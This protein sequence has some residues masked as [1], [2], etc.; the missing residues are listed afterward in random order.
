MSDLRQFFIIFS[1]H[2]LLFVGLTLILKPFQLLGTD[3]SGLYLSLI[4][5]FYRE[6]NF[7]SSYYCGVSYLANHFSPFWAIFALFIPLISSPIELYYLV[8]Y[9]GFTLLS[10]TFAFLYFSTRVRFSLAESAFIFLLVFSSVTVLFQ[11][12]LNFNGIHDVVFAASFLMISYYFLIIKDDYFKS[13]LFFLPT[14][15]I[16]E[17][18]FLIGFFY[19]LAVYVKSRKVTWF[20]VGFLFLFCFYL[21]H[22]IYMKSQYDGDEIVNL[23]YLYNYLFELKSL[24]YV[25]DAIINNN[26]IP[27][28]L[29][30][31]ATFFIPFVLLIDFKKIET[32][33]ILVFLFIVLP[34]VGYCFLAA[35]T[36]LSNFLFDHYGFPILPLIAV[37]VIKYGLF[38]H[39]RVLLYVLVNALLA[40]F[41][42]SQKQPWQYKYYQDEDK[43]VNKIIPL[44]GEDKDMVIATDERTGIYFADRKLA[45]PNMCKNQKPEYVVLN[46]RYLYSAM[47]ISRSSLLDGKHISTYDYL[48]EIGLDRYS[49]I[50]QEYPFLLFQQ[51]GIGTGVRLNGSELDLWDRRTEES[52]KWF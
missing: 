3:D 4:Y 32:K 36:R 9:L 42:V 6:W 52:N 49:L 14:L 45:A 39:K 40:V 46:T 31:I 20:S 11:Y 7:E 12:S 25:P 16:K 28:E 27:R 10:S 13:L 50:Y 30:L 21:V 23:G 41:I 48:Q 38:S 17:E 33:D 22:F 34:T 44:I 19:A 37:F 29:F 43:L 8:S 15:L 2:S 51:S 18:F 47:N 26:N 5:Q 24:A 35:G 1:I